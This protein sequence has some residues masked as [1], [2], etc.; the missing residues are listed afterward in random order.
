MRHRVQAGEPIALRTIYLGPDLLAPAAPC[1]VFEVEPLAREVFTYES[2]WTPAVAAAD[3]L[4]APFFEVLAGLVGRW[5]QQ[6]APTVAHT[7]Q[8][9]GVQ[10]VVDR[11]DAHRS[12]PPTLTE[13]T[14]AVGLSPRTLPATPA[15]PGTPRRSGARSA[16]GR[17]GGGIC[18]TRAARRI[19]L[20]ALAL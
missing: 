15:W 10:Q 7:A 11:V 14:V 20:R 8:T 6:E 16:L 5:R 3:P 4:A 2:R 19:A 12:T 13:A 18:R 17:W 1:C 9:A